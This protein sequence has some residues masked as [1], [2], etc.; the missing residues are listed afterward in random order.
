MRFSI[1][2]PVYNGDKY[3]ADCLESVAGQT[4]KDYEL[5]VVDDGS[6]DRSGAIAD[7]FARAHPNV[8]IVHGPNQGLLLARRRGLSEC[9]GEYVVFLDGDDALAPNALSRVS[10]VVDATGADIISFRY[11]RKRDYSSADD[12]IALDAKEYFGN[13]YDAVK[14]IVLR[15]RFNNLWGKAFRLCRID[16]DATY[17]AY[18]GLMLGEDLLQ[19]LPIVD[20]SST[21]TRIDDVLYYYRPNGSGSTGIYKHSYLNDSE[22]VA[23]RLLTYGRRWRMDEPAMDGIMILYVNVLRL[24]VRFGGSDVIGNELPL[25]SQSLARLSNYGLNDAIKR[26]RPDIRLLLDGALS[27][28]EQQVKLSVRATD[29]ARKVI[30]LR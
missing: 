16:I 26:Q 17:G 18:K 24:L 9:H 29:M 27:C 5:I 25:I 8:Q 12:S 4:C 7:A 13:Q 20:S 6:I 3:L 19:L 1:I 30:G 14:D 28:N 21:L 10:E 11:S 22:A 23:Q 15:A 2:V